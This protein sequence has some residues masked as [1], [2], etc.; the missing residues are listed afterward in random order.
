[1]VTQ[2]LQTVNLEWANLVATYDS[3]NMSNEETVIQNQY[4]NLQNNYTPS[5][6]NVCTA[7]GSNTAMQFA[8]DI[9]SDSACNIDQQI[10]NIYA[11]MIGQVAGTNGALYDMTTQLVVQ[12]QGGQ[13]LLQCYYVL[14]NYFGQLV[15]I[16]AQGLDLMI[17]AIHETQNTNLPYSD[18]ATQY[19]NK[20]QNQINAETE[21][22]LACV[23]RLVVSQVNV[24]SELAAQFYYLSQ[25]A[26]TI[27]NRADFVASQ[28]STQQPA[29]LVVRLIGDPVNVTTWIT[30]NQITANGTALIPVSVNGNTTNNYTALIPA[31]TPNVTYYLEWTANGSTYTFQKET[32]ISVVKLQLPTA[33]M[34]AAPTTYTVTSPTGSQTV[35]I[36]WY[37]INFNPISSPASNAGDPT[38]GA[39]SLYGSGVFFV[40][41]LP[42]WQADQGVKTQDKKN[43]WQ[44]TYTPNPAN[45]SVNIL[46][47]PC[48]L[49]WWTTAPITYTGGLNTTLCNGTTGNVNMEF[50]WNG[51]VYTQDSWN[52]TAGCAQSIICQSVT[53]Q[54]N[55]GVATTT[56][57][58]TL[59]PNTNTNVNY[60][61]QQILTSMYADGLEYGWTLTTNGI[62]NS[63]EIIPTS[64]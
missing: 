41:V 37:D 34:P 43:Q 42:T 36:G 27:Y 23:D 44:T 25:E 21:I 49:E 63:L 7:A 58:F 39:D 22:F 64:K 6:P 16:Q 59:D 60:Q 12:A 4:G 28:L 1:M 33:D 3:L 31:S 62:L 45:V 8:Q 32:N 53:Q 10:Y 56:S 26:T 13:D 55:S 40:R 38:S 35:S 2:L 15:A 48:D 57:N 52:D 54:A 11:Q 50:K 17:E 9:L 14:E 5:N 20:Y 19:Y 29:G 18:T 24:K 46:S 30:N 61:V 47:T 51:T